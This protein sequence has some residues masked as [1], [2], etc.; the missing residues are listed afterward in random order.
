MAG[1]NARARRG[2]RS[3]RGGCRRDTEAERRAPAVRQCGRAHFERVHRRIHLPLAALLGAITD[4][5]RG[6]LLQT[7]LRQT[8]RA[9]AHYA[10]QL[11]CVNTFDCATLITT[12]R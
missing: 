11:T 8:A 9:N 6:A 5:R 3:R 12:R 1:G 7:H 10:N 2:P 4:A